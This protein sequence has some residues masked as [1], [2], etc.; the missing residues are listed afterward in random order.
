MSQKKN[1]MEGAI[2]PLDLETLKTKVHLLDHPVAKHKMTQLRRK[3]TSSKHFRELMHELT[4]YLGFEAT[5]DLKTKPCVVDTP[6]ARHTGEEVETEVGLVPVLRSGLGMVDSMLEIITTAQVLHIGMYKDKK[7]LVS[8]LYYNRLPRVC[9]VDRAIILEP[10]VATA[11]TISAVV[12]ILKEWGVKEIH[13]I[14]VV[15]SR[16]GLTTLL[17][18]HPDV[19]V[20]IAAI[21][22]AVNEDGEIV[23]GIGDVGDRLFGT[24][25]ISRGSEPPSPKRQRKE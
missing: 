19:T 16:L 23:P 14:C 24:Q 21:D 17:D 7:S 25:E 4:L 22:D 1:I 18:A 2:E 10:V 6:H 11:G 3:E 12:E 15:A 20:H 13:L 9:A 5:K 8:T